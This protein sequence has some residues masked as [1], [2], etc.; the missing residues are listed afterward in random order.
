MTRV[1]LLEFLQTITFRGAKGQKAEQCLSRVAGHLTS[2][3]IYH[4]AIGTLLVMA[5]QFR[6]TS[7]SVEWYVG[8]RS[9]FKAVTAS[10]MRQMLLDPAQDE[11]LAA[12]SIILKLATSSQQP[13]SLVLGML[14]LPMYKDSRV[15]LSENASAEPRPATAQGKKHPV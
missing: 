14:K 11:L 15:M 13:Q 12:Y 6:W 4:C 3:R 1:N 7:I 2:A 8:T 10:Q 9:S 5:I